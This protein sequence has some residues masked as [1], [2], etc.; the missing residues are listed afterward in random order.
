[1]RDRYITLYYTALDLLKGRQ[2]KIFQAFS[3]VL[4]SYN[5]TKKNNENNVVYGQS[6]IKKNKI[7]RKQKNIK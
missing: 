4:F 5:L 3:R 2:K 1:M 6:L 7:K